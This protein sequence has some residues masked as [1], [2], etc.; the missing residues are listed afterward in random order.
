MNGEFFLMFRKAKSMFPL[1]AL[2]PYWIFSV[3]HMEQA[4]C[5]LLDVACLGYY[6]YG[7]PLLL[8]GLLI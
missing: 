5:I 6:H 4:V 1:I 2:L 8:A 3:S 7:L